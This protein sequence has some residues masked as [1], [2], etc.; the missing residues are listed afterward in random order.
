MNAAIAVAL[1]FGLGVVT[2]MPLGVINLA[3]V[4]AAS[5][6]RRRFAIG[7]GIGGGLADAVHAMLAFAGVGRVVTAAPAVVRGLAIGAAVLIVGY[8]VASWR[9][10]PAPPR[11]DAAASTTT[12]TA[13]TTTGL[14]TGLA[15]GLATGLALTLPNPG[16]LTAWVAVAAALFPDASVLDAALR[17]AGV[18]LGSALW[19]SSLAR[20]IS[21][22]RPD[23][24][25]IKVIPRLALAA[26]IAIA[27]IGVAR[28]F[29]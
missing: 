8:A 28:A 16:A 4:D 23:H 26:L 1:G 9:R 29:A 15:R 17:A 24:R 13:T 5:A 21:R 3:I 25:A 20:W 7:L 6:G 18:G 10:R 19:F 27:A 22:I 12:T 2:G 14:A 11:A